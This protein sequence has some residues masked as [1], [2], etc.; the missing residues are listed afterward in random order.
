MFSTLYETVRCGRRTLVI[1][2]WIY[3]FAAAAVVSGDI[4][5]K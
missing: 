4:R 1:H 3:E 5:L 2:E